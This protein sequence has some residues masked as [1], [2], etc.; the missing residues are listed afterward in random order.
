MKTVSF[1]KMVG[2]GND[3]V[4]VDYRSSH[5][6][7]GS[8]SKAARFLCERR[9]GVGADGVLVL[10]RSKKAYFKMRIFNADGSEAEM[11]GNG[12]RCAALYAAKK[13]TLKIETMAG[14]YEAEIRGKDKV[15]IKMGEPGDISRD[16][17]IKVNK[18]DIR[19]DYID[20]G[21]PHTVIFVEG[22]DGIDVDSIGRNIRY[23]GRFRPRGTNV[24]FVEI[25]D[26]KNIKMR[27]YERGV[28]GET[29]ACGTGAVASAIVSNVKCQVSSVKSGIKV[30]TRG[31]ILRVY[32]RKSKGK[33]KDLYLEGEA[34]RVY[35]GEV[36]YV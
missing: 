13:R 29:L 23:H 33:I 34:R 30:H 20:A 4:V 7:Y 25:V 15:R 10:E 2:A 5:A 32:F 27:T 14:V 28:E 11:C 9:N 35:N 1:T 16:L 21:V 36:L 26:D 12:L 24:D 3:F 8:L 31:G 19:V 6:G 22:I 17:R 18:R